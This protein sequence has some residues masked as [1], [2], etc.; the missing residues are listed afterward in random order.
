MSPS[1]HSQASNL[2]YNTVYSQIAFS[3]VLLLNDYVNSCL[4]ASKKPLMVGWCRCGS[5][6]NVKCLSSDDT[7]MIDGFVS[8]FL[9][10]VDVCVRVPGG[11]AHPPAG[12]PPLLPPPHP[13]HRGGQRRQGLHQGVV[14]Q[15]R[16]TTHLL[17]V[18]L[19]RP[20]AGLRRELRRA[21]R[22]PARPD[23][24]PQGD[25]L[26]LLAQRRGA[27]H[28]VLPNALPARLGLPQRTRR[29]LPAQVLAAGAV[30][31]RCTADLSKEVLI[32]VPAQIQNA[33]VRTTFL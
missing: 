14:F 18:R 26:H 9:P 29:P 25:P 4:I 31:K 32:R 19:R 28:Q 30:K 7:S 8:I 15:P 21:G 20:P 24:L 3:A 23:Q 13:L 27:H 22:L 12:L 6:T 17:P 11:S 1:T 10:V 2:F 16:R 5:W 33:P